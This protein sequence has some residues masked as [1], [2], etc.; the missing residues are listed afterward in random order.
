MRFAGVL[1]DLDGVLVDS[2]VAISRSM[3]HAL[4]ACGLEAWP[5]ERLHPLI[6]PPL[7]DAFG[8]LLD[9][10]GGD[11]ELIDAC[12]AR[13]RERYTSVCIEETLANAGIAEVLEELTGRLAL[14]VAT[15]KP[16]AYAVPILET[17][18]MAR[19]FGSVVGPS[20]DARGEP[21]TRTVAR[22]LEALRAPGPVAMVGDRLHD[23]VAGRANGLTTIGVTWGIGSEAELR[24]AGADHVVDSTAE[25]TALLA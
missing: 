23:V 22:A 7:H 11:H 24:D 10:Q 1:F 5:E 3:N 17:L 18:G 8:E 15:S 13:Y 4:E 12:V 9:E 2:R 20:L 21:K 14:G 25:L 16:E 6:G 19:F